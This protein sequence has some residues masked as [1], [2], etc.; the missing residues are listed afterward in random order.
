MP[1]MTTGPSFGVEL[2]AAA[3][4]RQPP[5]CHHQRQ[6]DRSMHLPQWRLLCVVLW[7][8]RGQGRAS[9]SLHE[10]SPFA[11]DSP[12]QPAARRDKAQHQPPPVLLLTPTHSP[13]PL[14]QQ[15]RRAGTMVKVTPLNKTKIVKKRTKKFG[16]F[17]ADRCVRCLGLHGGEFCCLLS[18]CLFV[19]RSVGRSMDG[20]SVRASPSCHP[21]LL[22]PIPPHHPPRT[23]QLQADGHLVAQAQGYR[24]PRA[25]A[26]QGRHAPAQHRLRCVLWA[27]CV[28]AWCVCVV[29]VCVRSRPTTILV[30]LT[31]SH[32]TLHP[33]PSP[34]SNANTRNL[35]PNGFYKFLVSNPKDVELLLLHNRCVR[36]PSP[37]FLSYLPLGP[38]WHPWAAARFLLSLLPL[39]LFCSPSPFT[40]P[41]SP[42]PPPLTAGNTRPRSRTTCRCGSARPSSRRRS[43]WASR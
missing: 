24:R 9:A 31:T 21:S 37:V 4:W 34:G 16:R 28:R 41:P 38:T 36:L 15:H 30:N 6:Q 18:V 39:L 35:L 8:I 42:P 40:Q 26:L 13:A 17:Q 27:V 43:S 1:V 2:R 25:A 14:P 7:S 19:H 33:L 23:K 11:I 22:S 32:P 29:C 3:W 12:L 10:A 5:V 20:R